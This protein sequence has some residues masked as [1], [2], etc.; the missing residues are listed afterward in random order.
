AELGR[1]MRVRARWTTATLAVVGAVLAAMVTASS[2]LALGVTEHNVGLNPGS[3]PNAITSGPDGNLWFTDQGCTG[4]GS[5]AVGSITTSGA[6]NEFGTTG[7]PHGITSGP[8]GA[9]WFTLTG[10]SAIGRATQAGS[11]TDFGTSDGLD[12]GAVTDGGIA[13]GA[14][15]NLWFTDEG[16]P[17]EIGQITLG[18]SIDEFGNILDPGAAPGDIAAG[19]DGNLWFTD[20]GSPAAIG[21][22]TTRGL[23]TEYTTGLPTGSSPQHI[24][25]GPDGNLWFS[26]DGSTPAIGKVTPAGVITEYSTGLNPGAKPGSLAVGVDGNIWFTDAGSTPA[27]GRI[28]PAGQI[29][30]YSNALP[31]GSSPAGIAEGADGDLWVANPG[32][33]AIDQVTLQLLPTVVTGSASG[34]INTA[35]TINGVVNP[36]GDAVNSVAVQYGTTTAYGESVNASPDTLPSGPSPVK[37]S[38]VPND[39]I[40]GTLYHYRVVATNAYGTSYGADQTFTTTGHA[41][42]PKGEVGSEPNCIIKPHMKVGQSHRRW[43]ESGKPA[44]H[45]APVG[46]TFRFQLT[47]PA[48]VKFVFTQQVRGRKVHGKCVAQTTHNLKA[49]GCTRNLSRGSFKVAGKKGTKKVSFKG[50]VGHRKLKPGNYTVA[51]TASNKAGHTTTQKLKFTIVAS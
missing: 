50:K 32:R 1:D 30:E 2:A 8:D 40:P 20:H 4:T 3:L 16:A 23:I 39:L 47:T 31:A 17:A 44:K 9:L 7:T 14:D 19:P 46:T 5:C 11:I 15:G 49:R 34:I 42:C 33:R 26:D 48:S 24:I 25:L 37:V 21:K 41:P 18:G 10:P 35:A 43:R 27:L 38:A 45:L 29:T 36:L 28:T 6:I 22:V 51:L 12:A 13:A